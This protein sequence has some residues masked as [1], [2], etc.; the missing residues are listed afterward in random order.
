[1]HAFT[2]GEL[3]GFARRAGFEDVRVPGEE[4]VASWF[5]WAN[6]TLEATAEPEEV[7]RLW[8]QYAYRG[9]LALKQVDERLL[10]PRLPPAIFYN[11]LVSARAPA[12]V[13]GRSRGPS[14]GP[15]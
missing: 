10:E 5:G 11:L 12:A 14:T 15:P 1:M 7:P 13:A 3:G 4:L 8:L 6:R 9:Y 2:P